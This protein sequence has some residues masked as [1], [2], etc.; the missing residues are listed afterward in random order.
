KRMRTRYSY[1][2][3]MGAFCT[4]W[5]RGGDLYAL[6]IFGHWLSWQCWALAVAARRCKWPEVHQRWLGLRGT[7]GG[8]I[9]GS[10]VGGG[11]SP[12]RSMNETTDEQM[13]LAQHSRNQKASQQRR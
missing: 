11:I 10:R 1:G 8:L 7:L 6:R 12:T 2:Y 4:L 5:L 13:N 3:G 9:Y